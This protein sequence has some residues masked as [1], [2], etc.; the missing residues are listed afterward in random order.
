MTKFF[1]DDWDT[2]STKLSARG[3]QYLQDNNAELIDERGNKGGAHFHLEF[4]DASDD[5]YNIYPDGHVT[6]NG[7]P[8]YGVEV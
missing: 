5:A 3:K 2:D 8:I 4:N 1:F 7:Y 6:G